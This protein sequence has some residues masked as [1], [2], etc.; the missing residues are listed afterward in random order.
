[1]KRTEPQQLSEVLKNA[2]EAY[3][4]D[5]RLSEYR[6]ADAWPSVVGKHIAELTG[7]P[8]VSQGVMMV[9]VPSPSLRQE[10]SMHRSS[11]LKALNDTVGKE[12]ILELRFVS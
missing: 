9:R 11:L 10:L 3:S 12:V 2:L 6:A 8:Y 7:R 1:M 5:G 4:L